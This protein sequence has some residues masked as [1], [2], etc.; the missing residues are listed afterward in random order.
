MGIVHAELQLSN[1]A[2]QQLAGMTETAVVDSGAMLLCLPQRV[3]VQLRLPELDRRIVTTADGKTH[4][5]PYVGPV[6]VSFANRFCNTDAIVI[7]DEVLLGAVQMEMMDVLVDPKNRRLVPNPATP[8]AP[9]Y[10]VK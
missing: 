5:C 2:Q 4:E 8:N 10:I 3:A 7:G 1:A 9:S 6:R